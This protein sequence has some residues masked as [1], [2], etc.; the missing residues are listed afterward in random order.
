VA[1]TR[2]TQVVFVST[3]EQGGP[4]SHLQYLLPRL[5]G[6]GVDVTLLCQ[7]EAVAST[8]E[9]VGVRSHPAP[10]RGRTD[11]AGAWKL[12]RRLAATDIV[13]TQDRRAGLYARAL[14]RVLGAKAVHTIH[15]IPEEVANRVGTSADENLLDVSRL[16][17]AW[18]THGYFRIE[19]MLA[20]LGTVV[21]PSHA[22]R[23]F[24]VEHGLPANRVLT[25]PSGIDLRRT[26]PQ[27]RH[28][29]MSIGT[30][31]NLEAWKGIDTLISAVARLGS[32]AR[33]EIWGD[34]SK[35]DELERQACRLGLDARFHGRTDNVRASI[36]EVDVFVL[37]SRAENL[38]MS[39]LEA[40]AGAVP[41]VA[42]P[43]GGVPEIITD[44]ANGYLVTPGDAPALA[45]AIEHLATNESVRMTLGAAGAA[46]IR[47]RFDVQNAVLPLVDLYQ[48]LC[49]SSN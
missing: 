45:A 35:R 31:A 18:L 28:E 34:G 4:I 24:L 21:T 5:R 32:T 1:L 40:M 44:G 19:A 27:P 29:P 37:P 38:P 42:T 41:V 2:H 36:E 13:H 46:T 11:L 26:Q 9:E 43:V 12:R 49:A 20:R 39:L 30:A 3:L 15:G 8:F 17:I 16:R 23:R 10:I 48:R 7:S 47:E 14:G 22:M 25:V 33:L 6:A